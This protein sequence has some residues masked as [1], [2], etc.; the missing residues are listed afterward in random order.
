MLKRISFALLALLLVSCGLPGSPTFTPPSSD[1]PSPATEFPTTEQPAATLAE[2]GPALEAIVILQPGLN[3]FL[4]SPVTVE[5]QSRPTFEQNLVVAIYGED[6]ARLAQQPTTLDSPAGEPG[7]YS[8]E[9]PFE[10]N[11]EQPGRI[12][13]YET[14]AMDGG[15][16]HLTSVAV[17][18]RPGTV[19]EINPPHLGFESIEIQIPIPMA[20]I[21]GG[22]ILVSGYS[23]YFFESNLGL[24][25]CGG[26]GSGAPNDLCGTEDNILA[27][28]NAMIDAPDVG[29]SGPFSGELTYSV[30]EPTPARIAVFAASPRD[31]GWMH[32]SSI[33]ILLSP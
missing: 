5:G 2:T 23:D 16:V 24:I 15:I 26:G 19:A 3:S 4:V 29:M 8:I 14:S 9:V 6:G 32:V 7:N 27:T 25:L 12:S 30:S 11:S 1:T 10:V 28:G 18:L 17:T 33:P 22:A 13:V 21:S 20:Q 31:G